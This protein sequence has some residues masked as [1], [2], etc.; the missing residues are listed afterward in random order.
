MFNFKQK[1]EEEPQQA[2]GLS[3]VRQESGCSQEGE[4]YSQ[5]EP[6]QLVLFNLKCFAKSISNVWVQATMPGECQPQ[7]VGGHAACAQAC[8]NLRQFFRQEGGALKATE[9][10]QLLC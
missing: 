9:V 4:A 3:Y 7:H 10:L 8:Q 6:G 2:S 1:S 5:R